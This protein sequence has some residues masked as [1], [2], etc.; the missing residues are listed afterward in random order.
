YISFISANT[1]VN[2]SVNIDS[3]QGSTANE[4]DT[5]A[6]KQKPGTQAAIDAKQKALY[7]AKLDS[8]LKEQGLNT[9]DFATPEEKKKSLFSQQMTIKSLTTGFGNLSGL[10]PI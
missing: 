7:E 2:K 4:I 10:L 9:N 3:K 1:K 8:Q 5:Y 6:E